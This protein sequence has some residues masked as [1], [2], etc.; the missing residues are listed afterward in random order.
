ME[1]KFQIKEKQLK[2]K[3]DI[4]KELRCQYKKCKNE[5]KV[6]FCV[7]VCCLCVFYL[8][9]NSSFLIVDVIYVIMV[10]DINM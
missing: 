9:L 8:M 3:D 6:E 10:T 5:N 1:E 4:I 7:Y 2:F